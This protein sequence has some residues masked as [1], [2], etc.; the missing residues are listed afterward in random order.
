[1]AIGILFGG[2]AMCLLMTGF[3]AQLKNRQIVKPPNTAHPK[4]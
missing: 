3:L 2:M 4:F 1:L